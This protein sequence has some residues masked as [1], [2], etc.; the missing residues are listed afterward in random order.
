MVVEQLNALANDAPSPAYS[1]LH[2]FSVLVSRVAEFC[3]TRNRDL[4]CPSIR[5][6][7]HHCNIQHPL[8]QDVAG[9]DTIVIVLQRESA[10]RCAHNR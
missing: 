10:P 8:A 5:T 2:V 6:Q 4:V 1:H 3:Q 9:G 7:C